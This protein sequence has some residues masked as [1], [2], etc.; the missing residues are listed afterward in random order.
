MS[1]QILACRYAADPDRRRGQSFPFDDRPDAPL[2]M[3][4]YFWV[5]RRGETTILV[6]TG[7]D[8]EEAARRGRRIETRP[9]DMLHA[10][11]IAPQSVASLVLTHLHFD[12]AGCLEA[13]PNALVHVQAA[14]VG[15]AT[16]PMMAHPVLGMP[17]SAEHVATVV[18][19]IHAGRVVLH[20]GRAPIA[21][22]VTGHLVGGHA[23]GLMALTVETARG[24]VIVAS[25]VAH[26]YESAVN[27]SI[28]RIVMDPEAMVRGY[29]WLWRA[30]EGDP[31]RIVPG[32]DPI[33]RRAFPRIGPGEIYDVSAAP[34]G[35]LP[36]RP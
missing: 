28:F 21:P 15:V 31:A 22:G 3:D 16:G 12:H 27:R 32:H 4:F 9:V 23:R 10:L 19:F 30:A 1:W 6:D 7:M 14:E 13:F 34:R 25:D 8:A 35:N 36:A 18:R 26:Y 2:P 29:D 33:V 20:E 24:P 17:Y 11:G 5:L